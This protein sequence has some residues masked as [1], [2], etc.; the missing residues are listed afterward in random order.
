[1]TITPEQFNKLLTK[2]DL[3]NFLSKNEIR[4]ISNN[5]LDKLYL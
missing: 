1:M 5:I 3:E 2:K 4:S